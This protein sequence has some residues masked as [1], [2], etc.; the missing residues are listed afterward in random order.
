MALPGRKPKPENMRRNTAKR[1]YEHTNFPDVENPNPRKIASVS[2]LRAATGISAW[3]AFTRRWWTSVAKLPHTV[4]WTDAE[5]D[6]AHETALVHAQFATGSANAA[7]VSELRKRNAEL[8]ATWQGRLDL[9]ITY[10]NDQGEEVREDRDMSVT[11][12]AD[13]RKA[14]E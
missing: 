14:V 6:F 1:R 10:R 11:A 5:W 8:G 13:Y 3:P 4:A 2:E 9:R 7:M 12:L